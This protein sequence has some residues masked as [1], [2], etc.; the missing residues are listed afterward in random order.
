MFIRSIKTAGNW[1]ANPDKSLATQR[2]AEPIPVAE[3]QQDS[4]EHWHHVFD[5]CVLSVR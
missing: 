2:S 5:V 3:E 4:L 1:Y